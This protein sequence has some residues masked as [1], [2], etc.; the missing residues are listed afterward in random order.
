[1]SDNVNLGLMRICVEKPIRSEENA[2]HSLKL[3]SNSDEHFHRL[4]AAFF[5]QKLWPKKSTITV[6]FYPHSSSRSI[7]S[8]TP[9][10]VMLAR[11]EPNGDSAEIDPIEYKIRNLSLEDGVRKVIEERIV[12]IC[13]LNFVFVPENGNVRIGFDSS[14][15]SWSL[16]GTDCLKTD[17]KTMNFAWLDASTIMHE[18]GHVLGLIHEHQNPR[19]QTIEWNV[20]IVD[21]WA[22]QTQGWSK[23]TTY[24]NII[25][26]YNLNQINGSD[27]DP[28]SI[29]LY[30]FPAKLT[31]NNKGTTMNLRLSPTDVEYIQKIYPGGVSPSSFYSQIYGETTNKKTRYILYVIIVVVIVLLIVGLWLIS[32]KYKKYSRFGRK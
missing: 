6:S 15:G 20:P 12:P 31:L 1:M 9:I 19:G 16:I 24:H 18:F 26:K 29:M 25:Q 4:R 14:N 32:R 7:A 2:L 11:R 17:K 3:N 13:G 30:Y 21:S 22:Q 23:E 10:D 8:W 5:T 28:D 27:F